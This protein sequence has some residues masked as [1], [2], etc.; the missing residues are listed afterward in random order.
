MEGDSR[1]AKHCRGICALLLLVRLAAAQSLEGLERLETISLAANTYHVQGIVVERSKLWV[2][3]VDTAGRRGLLM[4]FSLPDGK[5]SRSVEVQDGIR[6][7]PGG[8]S[9]DERSLWVPVAEYRKESSSVIQKRNKKTLAVEYQF[10]VD[11]HIGCVAV[12]PEHLI[13]AN[14]DARMFYVWNLRGELIRKVSNES[15]NAFQDLKFA[16]GQLVGG[17]LLAGRSGAIDWLEYPSFRPL[18]RMLAGKTDR[19]VAWTHEGMAI[20]D[21]TLWLLP[22][23]APSRLFGFRLSR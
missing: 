15:G 23:D 18:R 4:E 22:E 8:I 1:I 17:G 12:T 7:H 13:G 21:G 9:A 16:G 14:W 10:A 6:Y 20:N 19:G 5:L 11:D 3:S 2:S